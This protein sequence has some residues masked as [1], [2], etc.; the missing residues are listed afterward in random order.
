MKVKELISELQQY[1][2]EANVEVVIDDQIPCKDI[3][4]Y[5]G[6]KP[7]ENKVNKTTCKS[8]D[9]RVYINK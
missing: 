3:I 6:G 7:G 5:Y 9:L 1:N 2:T 8:V 4:L